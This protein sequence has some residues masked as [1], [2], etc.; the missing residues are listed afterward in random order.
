[1]STIEKNLY[2][3]YV[4]VYRS[5]IGNSQKV[6]LT[7]MSITDKYEDMCWFLDG[8]LLIYAYPY[9]NISIQG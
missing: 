3:V 7:K 6:E 2:K 8:M 5:N 4:S 9:K 1:M